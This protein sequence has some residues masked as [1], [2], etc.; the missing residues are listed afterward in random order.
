M[1]TCYVDGGNKGNG[2]SNTK[3]YG[4]FKIFMDNIEVKFHHMDFV[5]LTTNNEAEHAA[6]NGLLAYL[7]DLFK[8]CTTGQIKEI[9]SVVIRTDSSLVLNHLWGNWT[10]EEKF[11]LV[12]DADTRMLEAFP[13]AV[14]LEKVG[15]KEMKKILGH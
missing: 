11:D 15:G 1:I 5:G 4:S 13:V 2:T 14:N 7:T 12:L 9:G 8:R 3:P 6:L 10:H